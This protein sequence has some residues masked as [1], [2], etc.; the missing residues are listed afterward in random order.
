[1]KIKLLGNIYSLSYKTH[2]PALKVHS[3]RCRCLVGQNRDVLSLKGGYSL[4][5][6]LEPVSW[7]Y[8]WCN[9]ENMRRVGGL[10]LPG[11]TCCRT[12][13]TLDADL[14]PVFGW[15]WDLG[16]GKLNLDLC[17]RAIYTLP[18]DGIGQDPRGARREVEGSSTP[19][20]VFRYCLKSFVYKRHFF[21]VHLLS[22]LP[23]KVDCFW[24]AFKLTLP[25]T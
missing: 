8:R 19:F 20:W 10:T 12:I 5:T 2:L 13:W 24:G 21:M 23:S 4:Q 11:H 17:L 7:I 14:R 22:N 1:M 9:T 25:L 15:V 18:R 16:E 3:W 6:L